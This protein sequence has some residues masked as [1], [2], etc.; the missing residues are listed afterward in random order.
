MSD[1]YR[2]VTAKV[3]QVRE[4]SIMVEVPNRQGWHAI[5]RTLL[6]G[7][8]DL[9]MDRLTVGPDGIEQTFRVLEWKAEALGLAG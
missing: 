2:I 9:K 7:D 5:P 1:S 8:D 3:R 6:R 4:N